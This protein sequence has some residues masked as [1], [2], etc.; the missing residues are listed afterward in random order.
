MD[1]FGFYG[2]NHKY[3]QP[4]NLQYAAFGTQAWCGTSRINEVLRSKPED[5]VNRC[6]R[7]RRE[8]NPR[9]DKREHWGPWN[10]NNA[11]RLS[12]T[13]HLKLFRSP[14]ATVAQFGTGKDDLLQYDRA[15]DLT[16]HRYDN[17]DCRAFWL[18]LSPQCLEAA[19]KTNGGER[20]LMALLSGCRKVTSLTMHSLALAKHQT[21]LRTSTLILIKL[22]RSRFSTKWTAKEDALLGTTTDGEVAAKLGLTIGT[23]THRR[24]NFGKAVKFAHRR[25]WNPEEDA[26]LGTAPDTEIVARLGRHVSTVCIR[27]QKLGIPN[28]Y[29]QQRYGRQRVLKQA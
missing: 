3:P 9:I 16:G 13:M 12:M 5:Y 10:Q 4:G 1:Y 23:V 17:D 20:E 7:C 27:R 28:S 14:E 8:A 19:E 25:P 21:L 24:R 15:Q 29:W 26:L 11:R 6:P 22:L 18:Y 2:L